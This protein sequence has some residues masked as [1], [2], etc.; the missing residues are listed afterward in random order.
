MKMGRWGVALILIGCVTSMLTAQLP[1]VHLTTFTHP[2]FGT[3]GTVGVAS[4]SNTGS[5]AV[6]DFDQTASIHLFAN[7]GGLAFSGKSNNIIS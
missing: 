1:L 3:T 4:E 5:I 2:V 6:L 7:P